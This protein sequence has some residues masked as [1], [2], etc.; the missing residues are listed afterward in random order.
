MNAVKKI[1]RYGTLGLA[2][3]ALF[4]I[5]MG[6][7]GAI[8][9]W[10]FSWWLGGP[11]LTGGEPP[12]RGRDAL[13]WLMAGF[14]LLLWGLLSGPLGLRDHKRWAITQNQVAKNKAAD[15]E[16]DRRLE[17]FRESERERVFR[18]QVAEVRA[19]MAELADLQEKYGELGTIAFMLNR[20]IEDIQRVAGNDREN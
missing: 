6:I 11:A 16:A 4:T 8:F 12:M 15:E 5:L 17:E 13:A 2:G 19:R 3:H 18:E 14:F 10:W 20:P 7:G 1:Y 9:L